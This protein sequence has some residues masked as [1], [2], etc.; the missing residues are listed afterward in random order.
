MRTLV[1]GGN[2]F[3][4]SHLVEALR[5][6]GDR[7]RVL[8]RG[9]RRGDFDWSGIEYLQGEFSAAE[10]LDEALIGVDVVFHLASTSVPATSNADPLADIDGNLKGTVRLAQAML[11][12]GVRRIVYFSSGGTVYGNPMALPIPESHPTEPISSYG[13]VKLAVEKYLT[14]FAAQRG[15]SPLILRP[16]NPYGRRQST[17]GVQGV[18]PAFLGKFMRDEPVQVWGDGENRRDYVH[19]S[20]LVAFASHASRAGATGIFN[21]GSGQGHSLI[22]IISEMSTLLGSPLRVEHLP[23]RPFDVREVVLDITKAHAQFGWR[24]RVSLPEGL[25]ETWQWLSGHGPA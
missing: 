21:V 6:A 5:A 22:D 17:S 19:V 15:L 4:G 10:T 2:G 7:V 24:P 3:I 16:S 23:G 11:D 8:D 14:M 25:A 9:P 13:I 1:V 20:D 12:A 18:I